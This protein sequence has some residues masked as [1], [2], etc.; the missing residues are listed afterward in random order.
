VG[1]GVNETVNKQ[2]A[3]DTIHKIIY[4]FFDV[5][6]DDSEEPIS[7]KDKLL[8]AVNKAICNGIKAMP[9]AQPEQ[10]W[11]PCSERLPEYGQFVLVS[12]NGSVGCDVLMHCNKGTIWHYDGNLVLD[13]DAWQ[14][15]PEA[16]Q[17]G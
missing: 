14:P 1:N 9:S 6:E 17:E 16:Y 4:G 5:T 2:S 13:S 11:I 3:I 8:L 12:I 15:L 10:R 7:E